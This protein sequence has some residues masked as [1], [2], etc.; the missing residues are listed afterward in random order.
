MPR[1]AT[2][3]DYG[4]LDHRSASE[5]GIKPLKV[6]PRR[7]N[8]PAHLNGNLPRVHPSDEPVIQRALS[9]IQGKWRIAIL[10]QLQYGPVR[11]GELKRRIQTI[12]KKVLSQHLHR[13]ESDG[14]VTR[15]ELSGR[16]PHVEYALTNSLGTS[17]LRLIQTIVLWGSEPR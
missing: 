1:A 4:R 12:S 7:P 16:I 3:R 13:M 6:L 17:V 5:P 14:L 9:L 8:G 2:K 11:V 10:C 15:T